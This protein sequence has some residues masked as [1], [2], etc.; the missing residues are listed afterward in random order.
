MR[1]FRAFAYLFKGLYDLLASYLLAWVI[2]FAA[3][4]EMASLF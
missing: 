1:F 2:F 3:A 4:R